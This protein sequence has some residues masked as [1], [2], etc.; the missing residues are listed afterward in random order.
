MKCLYFP[1][2]SGKAGGIACYKA[3]FLTTATEYLSKQPRKER[4]ILT[5]HFQRFQ[6]ILTRRL[7]GLA[8]SM[9]SKGGLLT[10]DREE[11]E[12]TELRQL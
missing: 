12:K 6:S 9:A 1:N 2:S 4:F 10:R 5:H 7:S 8:S 11:V 3:A